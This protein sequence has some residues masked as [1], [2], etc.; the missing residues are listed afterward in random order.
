M[1]D[2]VFSEDAQSLADELNGYNEPVKTTGGLFSSGTSGNLANQTVSKL[3]GKPNKVLRGFEVVNVRKALDPKYSEEEYNVF[4]AKNPLDITQQATGFFKNMFKPLDNVANNILNSDL[5]KKFLARIPGD[6]TTISDKLTKMITDNVSFDG[7]AYIQKIDEEFISEKLPFIGGL[8]SDL[9]DAYLMPPGE[10]YDPSRDGYVAWKNR[11]D[12]RVAAGIAS[13]TLDPLAAASYGIN[14][15]QPDQVYVGADGQGRDNLS[16]F[17]AFNIFN[18]P[19]S[20][21]SQN[22]TYNP[23]ANGNGN[24]NLLGTRNQDVDNY[25]NSLSDSYAENKKQYGNVIANRLIGNTVRQLG[26]ADEANDLAELAGAL[27]PFFDQDYRETAQWNGLQKA[28]EFSSDFLDGSADWLEQ[29]WEDVGTNIRDKVDDTYDQLDKLAQSTGLGLMLNPNLKKQLDGFMNKMGFPKRKG[30]GKDLEGNLL[31]SLL[32]SNIVKINGL[33]LPPEDFIGYYEEHDYINGSFPKRVLRVRITPETKEKGLNAEFFSKNYDKLVIQ[34]Y[35]NFAFSR[36]QNYDF[37]SV[38]GR[39]QFRSFEVLHGFIG[40]CDSSKFKKPDSSKKKVKAKDKNS[41]VQSETDN[42]GDYFNGL[43]ILEI[44]LTSPKNE[45]MA[46]PQKLF[47]G[48][49]KEGTTVES[50]INETFKLHFNGQGD[51]TS[52]YIP[53]SNPNSQMMLAMEKPEFDKDLDTIKTPMDFKGI[54]DYYQTETGGALYNGG[55]NIFQDNNIVYVVRKKGPNKIEFEDSWNT[56]LRV[57]LSDATEIVQDLYNISSID[58]KS[59]WVGIT[60]DDIMF[61]GDY[62]NFNEHKDIP[63]YAG[64]PIIFGGSYNGIFTSSSFTISHTGSAVDKPTDIKKVSEFLVRIPNTYLVFRPGDKITVEVTDTDEVFHGTVKRW[65]SQ[66]YKG[67][68]CAVLQLAMEDGPDDT[69]EG[70]INNSPI[71]KAIRKYREWT[72]KTNDKITDKIE[73]WQS[74]LYMA[75]QNKD[76]ENDRITSFHNML[77]STNTK[78]RMKAQLDNGASMMLMMGSDSTDRSDL[79]ANS[80][81][82]PVKNKKGETVYNTGF[83]HILWGSNSNNNIENK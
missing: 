15:A 47:Q 13:E 31:S 65:A 33:E 50:V 66:Q 38:N 57:T 75:E 25:F 22:G 83:Q 2:K 73:K 27:D 40:T 20:T 32:F 24:F 8:S 37:F 41:K 1:F 39:A 78:E 42:I 6:D 30:I 46:K 74:K 35:R 5:G 45:L 18:T 69:D 28:K 19:T 21:F 14:M 71:N 82:M 58:E 23:T 29:T 26:L 3:T 11:K 62:D 77:L 63:L 54:L 9:L 4:G 53:N 76:P 60:A 79:M 10:H 59:T 64:S 7:G 55:Y 17:D 12:Q 48:V 34:F 52:T 44:T 43:D 36:S 61:L 56:T 68:R 16:N 67:I 51:G 81:F 80:A 72:M 70:V 49:T